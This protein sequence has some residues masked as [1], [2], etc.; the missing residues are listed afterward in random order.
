MNKPKKSRVWTFIDSSTDEELEKWAARLGITK[1]ILINLCVK[2]GMSNIIRTFA[3]EESLKPEQWAAIA[4]VA[5]KGNAVALP[6][7]KAPVAG[8]RVAK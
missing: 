7:G 5:G 6:R 3:P 2:A 1:S 8:K 4:K